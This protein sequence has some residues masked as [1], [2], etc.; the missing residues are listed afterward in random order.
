MS[1]IR[2]PEKARAV[3]GRPILPAW[4]ELEKWAN[5]IEPEKHSTNVRATHLPGETIFSARRPRGR[6]IFF[7]GAAIAAGKFAVIRPGYV[8]QIQPTVLD[9]ISGSRMYLDGRD[10][11]G[12]ETGRQH[13]LDLVSGESGGP[14][15]NG[16]SFLCLRILVVRESGIPAKEEL[17]PEFLSVVHRSELPAGFFAGGMPEEDADHTPE[18]FEDFSAGVWPVAE[19]IWKESG[20][21]VLRWNQIALHNLTHRFTPSEI[22]AEAA[23]EG[24][25]ARSRHWF[26]GVT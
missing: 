15:E 16:R 1:S 6:P 8:N 5:E 17:G 12:V 11:D 13:Y 25:D 23:A 19:L 2:F 10:L 24:K 21:L 18:G 4:A 22:G 26:F 9:S 20:D 14:G 7:F 3:P